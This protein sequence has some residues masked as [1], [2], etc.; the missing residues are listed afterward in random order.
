MNM[1]RSKN[2]GG[3][4]SGCG[5]VGALALG[6]HEKNGVLTGIDF[7]RMVHSLRHRG[8]EARGTW[9]K[10]GVLLGHTRLSILDL[11]ERGNQPMTRDHLTI[12]L[13]GEIYN[14]ADIRSILEQDGI[15]FTSGT[16]T[17]VVLR[18]YQKWGS[19]AL[20]KFNGMFAFAAWDD[21]KKILF[22]AR[23]RIGIKPFY[24]YKDDRVFL[25]GSEV[26]ALMHSGCIAPE[27]DEEALQREILINAYYQ[28]DAVR[29]MVKG[30]YSLPPG[31]F[32]T[33]QRGAVGGSGGHFK[34]EKYWD[35][36]ETKIQHQPAPAELARELRELL[37]D[38]VKLRLVSDVPV[39]AFL[40]GGMDS[41][42]INV[43]AGRL[44]KDYRLTAVTV[45]YEGG[46]RD[47]YSDSEDRDLEYSRI[48]ADT[49]KE[50][51]DHRI[52]YMNPANISIAAIDEIIDLAS[53]SDDVRYLSVA[54]NY[55]AVKDQGFKV[56]LNGQGADEI[57]G[58]YASL[59]F[60]IDSML[61]VQQP[62]L[63]L[64][65]NSFPY[66]CFL[67]KNMLNEELSAHMD[68]V[69]EELHRYLHHFP[70]D[71]L[72]K[73]HRYLM[74]TELQK[75][76]KLEDFLSMR[77][78][79][80]CRLP[81]LDYR[82]IEWAFNIPFQK[83]IRV[84][85]RMGKQLLREAVKD[86]LPKEVIDRPKQAF[87]GPDRQRTEKILYSIY[88]EHRGE[89][90]RSEILRRVFKREVFESK[91][92]KFSTQELWIIITLWRWEKKLTAFSFNEEN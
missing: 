60:I 19:A 88:Q 80:E 89:I 27:I 4:F 42:V 48:V 63:D 40:S 85:D 52:I 84:R 33:V 37:E 73:T 54:G 82:I 31:H 20:H 59:K 56:V 68:E 55:R 15:R 1:I 61:D 46:G 86:L 17:E 9:E 2:S 91:T 81:F 30:V 26:Q 47:I 6:N 8:P 58:G 65:K 36:P 62:E 11:S 5:I 77:S 49:L 53:F 39:A 45:A 92:A 34:V 70:G 24:Y 78:S 90:A 16:D 28:Y 71:L 35:L 22:A 72:E 87:P 29:T 74:N 12:I 57:M 3:P 10:D 76:L 13:N 21:K 66:M 38:S 32:M 44:L 64:I 41:S 25:F 23:D 75:V 79:V 83:H 51:V 43:L 14:F 69:Y 7:N 50:K 18:A 67:D